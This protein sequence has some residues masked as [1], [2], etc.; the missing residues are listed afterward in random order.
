MKRSTLKAI[1]TALA[2]A[3]LA[4]VGVIALSRLE[5]RIEAPPEGA[6]TRSV[7]TEEAGIS[8]G[9][10]AYV[11]TVDGRRYRR[12]EELSTL[13]ILGTDDK[14]PDEDEGA[15]VSSQADLIVLAIFDRSA[16]TCTLLQIDR[17]TMAEV[18]VLDGNDRPAG[19]AL[20]QICLA[21]D[22]GTTP[23]IRCRNTADA[24]S[25]LLYGARVDNYVSL[26]MGGVTALNDAVG[27]VTVT[28]EDDFTGVDD[29]LIKGETVTLMGEH[30]FNFVHARYTMT[31]DANTARMRRQR[32]YMEG[33]TEVLRDGVKEEPGFVLT[34]FDAIADYLVT[35]CKVDELSAYAE[36]LADYALAGFIVPEGEVLHREYTEFHPDEDALL[37]LALELFYLPAE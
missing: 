26:A 13:L 6:G 10:D 22:Y 20:E 11:M 9:E 31:D 17:N 37:D 32:A 14:M 28:V 16:R 3:V 12:N 36:G 2:V 25:R 18:T 33:L 27:G 15:F 19:T 24:V 23:E 21:H 7:Q 29:T 5:K 4:V 34:V 30:A 8:G 1:L 35:D